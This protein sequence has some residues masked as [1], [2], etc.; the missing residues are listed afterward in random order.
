MNLTYTAGYHELAMSGVV[1]ARNVQIIVAFYP[2]DSNGM[3][4]DAET[5]NL[6]QDSPRKL[7]RTYTVKGSYLFF[8]IVNL[9]YDTDLRP[10]SF[11]FDFYL[12]S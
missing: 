6:V 8:A 11:S 3:S 12:T 5:I 2:T 9:D 1:W 7:N 4:Y 10:W